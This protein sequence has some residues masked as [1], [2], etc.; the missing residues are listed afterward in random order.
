MCNAF[1]RPKLEQDL[2]TLEGHNDQWV[3][4][5]RQRIFDSDVFSKRLTDNNAFILRIGHHSGAES[6]TMDGAR[7]IQIR[8]SGGQTSF[9]KQATTQWFTADQPD[10][11]TGLLPFGWLLVLV[12]KAA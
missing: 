2:R 1:Y 9:E 7:S 8:R 12:D 5:V 6:V 4:T 3:Q 10:S 11:S